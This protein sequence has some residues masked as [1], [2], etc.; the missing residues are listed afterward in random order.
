MTLEERLPL[1]RQVA[2]DAEVLALTTPRLSPDGRRLV[3]RAAGQLWHQPLDGGPAQ[4][5]S[6]GDI[7]EQAPVFSPD[8]R[9]LAFLQIGLRENELCVFDFE[10]GERRTVCTGGLSGNHRGPVF[11]PDGRRVAFVTDDAAEVRVVELAS[12]RMRTV[13]VASTFIH[14]GFLNWS[15]DGQQLVFMDHHEESGTHHRVIS[16]N[17]SDGTTTIIAD[18][19]LLIPA[20]GPLKADGQLLYFVLPDTATLF[21]LSFDDPAEREP[22]MPMTDFYPVRVSAD[23]K[24]LALT[25]PDLEMW[26]VGGAR[27]LSG[28]WLAPLDRGRVEE[29]DIQLV[30]HESVR[31]FSFTPDGTAL[32]YVA[33][34]RIWR[35]PL[36]GGE[37]EEIPIR[38]ER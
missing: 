15:H 34:N 22:I 23:G 20:D 29:S 33:G 13:E 4:R 31:D 12:G 7:L 36:L 24:W 2:I 6:G 30:S 27:D 35:Q 32:I 9:Y 19:L 11:S 38:I 16:A 26:M 28:L 3:F 25:S 8:G 21:S 17:V 1:F 10:T 14:D 18:V 37:R 5:L